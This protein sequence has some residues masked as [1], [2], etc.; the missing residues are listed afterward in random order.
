MLEIL[1]ST[2]QRFRNKS[3]KNKVNKDS[4]E[5]KLIKIQELLGSCQQS[6]EDDAS[7][8][9]TAIDDDADTEDDADDEADIAE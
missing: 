1:K 7:D 6:D 9:D 3:K 2:K 4:L 8:D 5:Q